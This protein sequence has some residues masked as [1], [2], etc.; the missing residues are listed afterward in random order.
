MS[1]DIVLFNS[2][3][4]ITAPEELDDT[5]LSDTDFAAVF[6]RHFPDTVKDGN[7]YYCRK[8]LINCD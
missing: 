7:K 4:K 3:Q 5:Q 6:D 2:A 8:K 1:W